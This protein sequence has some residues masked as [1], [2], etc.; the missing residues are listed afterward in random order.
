MPL[1]T[2]LDFA[3]SALSVRYRA[4]REPQELSIDVT[5]EAPAP[6][7]NATATMESIVHLINAGGAGGEHFAPQDSL[8]RVLQAPPHDSLGPSYHWVLEV[9]SV[10][11]AFLRSMIDRLRLV[12][13]EP[14]VVGMT[15][16]G[17]L[18]T[19]DSALSVTEALMRTWL[20]SPEAYPARWPQLSFGVSDISMLGAAAEIQ[21][22]TEV[23]ADV[24][25]ELEELVATWLEAVIHY[26][27]PDGS[28]VLEEHEQFHY[29]SGFGRT[30]YRFCIQ[31]FLHNHVPSTA[32]LLNL[33]ERF[34]HVVAPIQHA[35]VRI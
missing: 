9:A 6:F 1:I 4:S 26:V 15:L 24:Y 23:T 13:G 12:G 20:D 33:L 3:S 16:A 22:G 31:Q 19:D 29:Q 32:M 2:G 10:A 35:E 7:H 28:E 30:E 8:A 17:S 5:T 34:H 21:L 11:P 27:E 25:R 14:A 18:P